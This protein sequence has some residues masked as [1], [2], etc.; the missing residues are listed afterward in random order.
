MLAQCVK[1]ASQIFK[2]CEIYAT[3]SL[4]RGKDTQTK[5]TRIRVCKISKILRCYQTLNAQILQ[6]SYL[7]SLQLKN[8][9][10]LPVL[11]HSS[12]YSKNTVCAA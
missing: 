4:M 5:F 2:I 7:P 12:H 8:L 3:G 6:S 9:K 1:L 10:R 11:R